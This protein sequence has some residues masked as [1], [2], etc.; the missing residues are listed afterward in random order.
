MEVK[1]RWVTTTRWLRFAFEDCGV[2]PTFPARVH[3]TTAK[4]MWSLGGLHVCTSLPLG[5]GCAKMDFHISPT[6]MICVTP[7][8]HHPFRYCNRVVCMRRSR[9]LLLLPPL[10]AT[11]KSLHSIRRKIVAL[12]E[13][14]A[15][16]MLSCLLGMV[17]LLGGGV[18]SSNLFLDVFDPCIDEFLAQT[19]KWAIPVKLQWQFQVFP[20]ISLSAY[21]DDLARKMLLL[22][23]SFSHILHSMATMDRRLDQALMQAG[24]EQNRDQH[25]VPS[26][27][28]P[29]S[30]VALRRV[31]GGAEALLGTWGINTNTIVYSSQSLPSGLKAWLKSS[32]FSQTS[33]NMDRAG[34]STWFIAGL[35]WP[36]SSLGKRLC[37]WGLLSLLRFIA[38]WL[39]NCALWMAK[40]HRAGSVD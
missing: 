38:M 8:G 21:A 33:G 35:Y 16:S 29:G 22:R 5:G 7:S 12:C 1:G 2:L 18:F 19:T 31:S 10:V 4:N 37:F 32:A 24:F 34:L 15:S 11:W 26:L 9:F 17:R 3:G 13:C 36:F 6:S 14:H 23:L 25:K 27:V 39:T 30:Q 28:G 40:G 20:D